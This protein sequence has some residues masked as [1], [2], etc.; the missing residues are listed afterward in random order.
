MNFD[1]YFI[2]GLVSFALL[3]LLDDDFGEPDFELEP[4]P[5]FFLLPLDFGDDFEDLG[6]ADEADP[7]DAAAANGIEIIRRYR[8]L[9]VDDM[10]RV[11]AF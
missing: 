5:F 1:L 2:R 6:F 4:D 8:I 11:F 3:P 9:F 7:E 10:F